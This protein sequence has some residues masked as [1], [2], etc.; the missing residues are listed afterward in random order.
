M[1]K[2]FLD[3]KGLKCPMPSLKMTQMVLKK[4]VKPG[5]VLE[6]VADCPTFENDVRTW[7][8]SSKKVLIFMR[9]EADGS[10]CCQVQI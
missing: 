3:A 5:D 6:V 8:Q 4:E 1:A 10:K 9:S 7:C 2:A